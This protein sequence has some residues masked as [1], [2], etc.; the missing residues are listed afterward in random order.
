MKRLF[1][2]VICAL[3]AI[4]SVI[5][6]EKAPMLEF[7]GSTSVTIGKDGGSQ[8]ITFTANRDWSVSS[9]ESWCKVSPASGTASDAPVSVTVTCDPN[10]TYDARTCTVTVRADELSQTITVTQDTGIGL[11]VSQ[12]EYNLSNAAQTIEVEVKANVKYNVSIDAEGAKWITNTGTKGLSSEK[13]VFN[14]AANDTYDS[15]VGKITISQA[16]G[17]LSGIITVT[18]GQTDGLFITEPNYELS[19]ASHTLSV[20]VQSNIDFEVTPSVSWIKYVET[21]ALKNSTIILSVEANADYDAREGTVTVKQKNGSLSGVIT[22]KQGQND[23]LQ[24]TNTSYN[25]TNQSQSLNVEVKANVA[26]TVSPS[27]DWIQYVETKAL[28]TSTVV[29][30]IKANETYGPREGSVTIKQAD[31]ALAETVTIKQGQTDGIFITTP[32]YDLSNSSHDL[33]IEVQANVEYTVTPKV[34]WI[35]FVQTKALE[36]SVITLSVSANETYDA[37]EGTVEVKQVN[38][39]LSGTIIIRQA[40]NYGLFVSNESATISNA[41]QD[42]EVTVQY[43]V[44]FDLVI[45]DEGKEMLKL[46]R[47]EGD[48]T[49]TKALSSRKYIF[50]IHENTTYDERSAS[51]TFKQRDGS[52]SGTFKITQAQMDGLLVDKTEYDFDWE[53][54]DLDIP[55]MANVDVEVSFPEEYYWI[56]KRQEPETKGLTENVIKLHVSFNPSYD[57][58]E[59]EVI[60]KQVGGDLKQTV[61]VNQ[62][63]RKWLDMDSVYADPEGGEYKMGVRYN[64]PYTINTDALPDWIHF[65]SKT[66]INKNS[67]EWTWTVDANN[68][69]AKR[70]YELTAKSEDETTSHTTTFIQDYNANRIIEFADIAAKNACVEMFDTNND[71][72]IS[73]KEA[74]AATSL[75]GLFTNWAG[76]QTFDELKY[77]TNVHDLAGVFKDC[78]NFQSIVIPEFITSIGYEAFCEC[79]H[80]ESVT[81]PSK[82]VLIDNKAFWDCYALESISIPEGVTR[83]GS[84]AFTGS[85]LKNVELPSTLKQIDG[86][87]FSNSKLESLKLNNGLEVIDKE[88]FNGTLLKEVVVPDSVTELGDGVFS[89]CYY[90]QKATLPKNLEKIS[91]N[92]FYQCFELEDITIP[93]GVTSIGDYAFGICSKLMSL[94]IPESVTL[95]GEKAF[96]A[97]SWGSRSQQNLAFVK[98]ESTSAPQIY[99]N[100]FGPGTRIYVPDGAESIYKA[101]TNWADIADRIFPISAYNSP[102]IESDSDGNL[103]ITANGATYKLIKVTSGTITEGVSSPLTVGSDFWLGET[104]IPEA[105]WQYF[106]G[107]YASTTDI[108]PK[109]YIDQYSAEIFLDRINSLTGK[110]FRLPSEIEWEYAARG[111][112]KTHGYKFSGSDNVDDVAWYQGNAEGSLHPVKQKAPNELGFY[113]MSGNA[114]EG[115]SDDKAHG[116]SYRYSSGA[117]LVWV[118]A[119]KTW[120]VSYSGGESAITIRLAL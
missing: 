53:D 1:G 107:G 49:D 81:L 56:E 40:E 71:G 85:G 64:L 75:S 92:L 82:I 47:Y 44:D 51:I 58:R 73:I 87:A 27:V 5:S 52:L 89:L 2:F 118:T 76:V 30:S 17:S 12:T 95:I 19:N 115:C 104:E 88:A 117:S 63:A 54:H 114:A 14:I 34:D 68:T 32:E 50:T 43:N 67:D 77:F 100:T 26:F 105:F 109:T 69:T 9:S 113:D 96:A 21:K 37:R 79:T 78:K 25:L 7:T 29:L 102:T 83:I 42:V 55:V 13:I 41:E 108:Y 101:R 28:S 33:S 36:S 59:G 38:G 72:E 18:Q 61:K 86:S 57:P 39:D 120:S 10:T 22:I 66:N 46:V 23:G 97:D 48:G 84:Y 31:G 91:K 11:I 8:T 111:G 62:S 45:P 116:G 112:T 3:V 119:V 106:M 90:L 16:D 20:E 98:L 99:D 35:Q 24:V 60:I 74:Q 70:E 110:S 93:S 65:V 94:T 80:L 4:V 103:L 6:C 15:R